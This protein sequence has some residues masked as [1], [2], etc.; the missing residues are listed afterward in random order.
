MV[1][2]QT[3]LLEDIKAFEDG[4]DKLV[5]KKGATV[6]GGQRKRIAI[7]RALY[8]EPDIIFFDGLTDQVDSKTE[9]KM[10]FQI[11]KKF[12]GII[13]ISSISENIVKHA[14]HIIR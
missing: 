2:S 7:A 3:D 13:F 10:V 5:G 11:L 12:S 14:N 9:E 1:L 6:S 8:A 4:I